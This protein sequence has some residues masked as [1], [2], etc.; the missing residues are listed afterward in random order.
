MSNSVPTNQELLDA[1][2]AAVYAAVNVT[3]PAVQE[4]S[5]GAET[6]VKNVPLSELKVWYDTVKGE[7]EAGQGLAIAYTTWNNIQRYS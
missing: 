5:L 7:V 1:L 4:Y 6:T 3:G 2:R